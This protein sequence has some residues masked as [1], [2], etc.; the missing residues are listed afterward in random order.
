MQDSSALIKNKIISVTK[1]I[2]TAQKLHGLHE[3]IVLTGGCFDI[4]HVG[5]IAFLQNASRL[6]D[7]TLV[8]LENDEKIKKVKGNDRPINSQHDRAVILASLIYT[9]YIITLPEMTEDKKYDEMISQL[10]PAI[11]ATTSQDPY[12]FHKERQAAMTGAKVVDVTENISNK[13][14]SKIAIMLEHEL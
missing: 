13:S 12:R 7:K 1:A 9:D 10:K 3:T 5:H 8:L 2:E 11:I 4:L 6:A 14:T